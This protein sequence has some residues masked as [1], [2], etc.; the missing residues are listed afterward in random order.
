MRSLTISQT[1]CVC[2]CENVC[3][4]LWMSDEAGLQEDNFDNKIK[5]DNEQMIANETW[6]PSCLMLP[7]I[8]IRWRYNI[9]VLCRRIQQTTWRRPINSGWFSSALLRGLHRFFQNLTVT[10]TLC[11]IWRYLFCQG[12]LAGFVKAVCIIWQPKLAAQFYPGAN[13]GPAG[14]HALGAPCY[15]TRHFPVCVPC[16]PQSGS[17]RLCSP[18]VPA[19]FLLEFFIFQG[20]A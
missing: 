15:R 20:R 14:L 1:S 19:L 12:K 6:K 11:Q 13:I 5:L 16:L 18:C 9:T 17:T 10:S 8:T 4:V 7:F 2:V 3:V